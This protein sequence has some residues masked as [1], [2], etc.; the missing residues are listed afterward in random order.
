MDTTLLA[1]IFENFR[2]VSLKKYE[3]DPAYFY[4]TPGLLFEACLKKT[5][6]K[7]EILTDI[8]MLLT[9]E[10][11]VRGGLSQAVHRYTSANNKYMTNHD[12]NQP[13]SYI[14]YL[15]ANNLYG[16]A[17]SKKLPIGDY[18]FVN[19]H[20]RCTSEF[21]ENYDVNSDIGYLFEVDVDYPKHLHESHS[22]LPFLPEKK[23]KLLVTLE[24]KKIM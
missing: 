18:T 8:D 24:D 17:M 22:D 20:S 3:L 10:K 23:E 7:I 1:D 2:T 9:Y 19:D 14:T 11:G 13:S 4:T 21:I 6:K 5:N 12:P 16:W 15:D